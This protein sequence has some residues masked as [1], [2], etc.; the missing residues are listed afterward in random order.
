MKSGTIIIESFD[1]KI[2]KNNPLK[3]PTLRKF[4][5]YLPP[6]YDS[7]KNFPVVYLLNGFTGKG[8]Q[9]LN[10]SFLSENIEE[11]LNRLITEKIIKEM[12]VVMPDCITKYGGSQFINSKG[13]GNYE[14]YLI[15][16]IIPFIDK[17]YKTINNSNYRAVCGKSSGGFGAIYLGMKNPD[18]F[19][20]VC[21]T[22]GDM[23][24]EYCYQKDF[25]KFVKYISN[26][27]VGNKAVSNFIK[28]EIN[29]KQ[30]K[31]GYFHDLINIIGMASCYSPNPGAIK[32][33]GYNFDLPFDIFTGELIR[34]IFNTWKKFDP[35][36]LVEK[37]KTN[38]KKLNLLYIDVGSKDE[39]DL[40]IGA[41][42]FCS[43]LNK[44]KIKY[45]YDEF[46]GGHFN[47][48]YRYD[49]TFKLIS[50]NIK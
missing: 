40:N 35:V 13:T 45:L 14:D 12:I 25:P 31:P 11:R 20:L 47:I 8:I 21:S 32:T 16:E 30:P 26:Y 27:G 49:N 39:F 46:N 23:Y 19:K 28:K 37:Y 41:R 10:I 33:K 15:K 9:N 29:F 50:D 17:K 44:S 3:D 38:F 42:I 24:F 22:S 5:V 36:N 6:S 48:Q 34:N 1:S 43:K 2:L 4:P 7:R 18:I